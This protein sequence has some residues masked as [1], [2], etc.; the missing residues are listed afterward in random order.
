MKNEVSSSKG[1]SQPINEDRSSFDG[2]EPLDC[3]FIYCPNQ[4]FDVCLPNCSRG[5]VRLVGYMIRQTLGFRD[6]K[7]SPIRQ[8]I[9]IRYR[10][11]IDKA[12]I[13]RGAVTAAVEE[14]LRHK[15][16]T[17]QS[18]GMAK[19]K[20]CASK[21]ACFSL[22]WGVGDSYSTDFNAF[23]GFYT[24][25]GCRTP[26]PVAFFDRI[27]A[28]ETL[29]VTKVVG[30]VLRYTVGYEN[31]FGR[32]EQAELS[33]SKIQNFANLQNRKYIA[34]AIKRALQVG[35]IHRITQGKF[36]HDDSQR[37]TATY[38]VRW[39][40]SNSN[41]DIG[42]TKSP[43]TECKSDD[44]IGSKISPGPDRYN[45]GPSNSSI[46]SLGNQF[47]KAPC[48]EKEIL[49]A[50][51]KQAA[52]ELVLLLQRQG[53]E[54]ETSARLVESFAAKVICQQI[55]WID[56]RNPSRNRTGLLLRAIRE[57]WPEPNGVAKDQ[58]ANERAVSSKHHE[59][60][61]SSVVE[62]QLQQQQR[63]NERLQL[64]E[65]RLQR[66][67]MLDREDWKLI[68]IHAE[69]D[70]VDELTKRLIRKTSF[71]NPSN[72]VLK[73]MELYLAGQSDFPS[74]TSNAKN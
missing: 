14:A 63:Q 35:Y 15:F 59:Q 48:K 52:A 46:K 1:Q 32:V 27:V 24:G 47:K 12:G 20:G 62:Q 36:H 72:E 41:S 11:F 10:D 28:T 60:K 30:T 56:D 42:S 34:K 17:Q 69:M 33:Y 51:N 54:P 38:A 67:R 23:A 26:I 66:W 68:R 44:V 31:Q 9:T 22:N 50:N 70:A 37:Q 45:N 6:G 39:L 21:S 2:F 29:A 57:N 18:S 5:T 64:R 65:T 53:F 7:G 55:D 71:E 58:K 49:K 40:G 3:N 25:R 61:L 8:D 4:F 19:S 74:P 16:I 73:Q 43:A 13:S